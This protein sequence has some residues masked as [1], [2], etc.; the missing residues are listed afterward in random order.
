MPFSP[1]TYDPFANPERGVHQVGEAN[2]REDII[3]RACARNWES[4]S[5]IGPR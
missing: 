1:C 3:A 2:P 5:K 4:D